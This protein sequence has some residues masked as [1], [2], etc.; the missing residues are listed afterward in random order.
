MGSF[1]DDFFEEME[2]HMHDDD[3]HEH[4]DDD[5]HMHDEVGEHMH[6]DDDESLDTSTSADNAPEGSMHNLPVPDAIAAVRTTVAN[7]LG[8]SEGVVI[9][10]SAYEQEWPNGCLGLAGDGEMCT[11]ALVSGYQV[12]VLA[13]GNE[14]VFRTSSDGSVLREEK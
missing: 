4:E 11:E 7:E 10:L 8:I 5:G 14:R 12:T 6:D 13:Q 1:D 3:D 2:E 9:V